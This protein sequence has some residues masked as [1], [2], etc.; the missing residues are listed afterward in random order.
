MIK[1]TNLCKAY[2]NTVALDTVSFEVEDGHIYGLLGPNGAGKSTT[3]NIITGYL[4]PTQGEVCIDGYVL[5]KDT[6]KAKKC[7]GYLPENPPL[8]PDM[9]VREY[10]NFVASLK[11]IPAKERIDEVQSVIDK[12]GLKDVSERLI[13][14][15]SKG[16]KQRVGIAQAIMGSPKVI[17]LDEP[18]VGLDPQQIIEIREL[19]RSLKENHTV[20]LSSH[21][22]SEIATVCDDV[23]MISHGRVVAMDTTD[24]LLSDKDR[25]GRKFTLTV[26]GEKEKTEKVLSGLSKIVKN[27]AFVSEEDGKSTFTFETEREDD[28]REDVSFALSDER[29]LVLSLN[30]EKNSLED[31]Y[32]AIMEES[33]KQYEEELRQMEEAEDEDDEDE[34]EED[35]DEEDEES[36][37]EDADEDYDGKEEE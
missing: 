18:T 23:L 9:F 3:M 25:L 13:K 17:I 20:I 31:I 19:I 37:D 11:Q 27:L 1:V 29:I 33:D 35:E 16:Y 14:N 8:Y 7:I 36:A 24:H 12:T 21:I 6:L 26:K 32:L 30:E 4:A 5:G 2:G 10:L 22:L 28:I 15:L 34:D